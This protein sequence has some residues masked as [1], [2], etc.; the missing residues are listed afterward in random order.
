MMTKEDIEQK[1]KQA[2]ERA[3]SEWMSRPETRF[4]VSTIPAGE[5]K[6]SLSVLLRSAFSAGHG[7]GGAS[8]GIM[9]MEH[10]LTK[11][12]DRDDRKP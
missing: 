1:S 12:G 6:E 2:E 10:A 9:L 11:L 4:I 5:H 7:A 8:V 3:F